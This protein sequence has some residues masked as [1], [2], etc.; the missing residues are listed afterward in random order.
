M[1]QYTLI[2]ESLFYCILLD[3]FNNFGV[4]ISYTLTMQSISNILSFV[5]YLTFLAHISS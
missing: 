3:T 4:T 5:F 1:Q 2:R